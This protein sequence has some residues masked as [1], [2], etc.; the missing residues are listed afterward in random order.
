MLTYAGL[1]YF[2][3]SLWLPSFARSLN[4]PSFAGPLSLAL[5]NVAVVFGAVSLGWL[6]D[7]CHAATA[8][9][10]STVGQ[11]VAI[12]VFWGLTSSQPMLYI[13]AMLWGVFAGGTSTK[14]PFIA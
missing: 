3:P 7:R 1:G 8:V 9:L 11:A 12:F 5:Y 13:F 2:V 6:V 14:S 4:M 10:V